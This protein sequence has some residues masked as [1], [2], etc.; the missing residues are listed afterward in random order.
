MFPDGRS[1]GKARGRPQLDYRQ[2][3]RSLPAALLLRPEGQ[4]EQKPASAQQGNSH[5][6]PIKRGRLPT[7]D[8]QGQKLLRSSLQPLQQGG[9]T[10]TAA[11][12]QVEG[13]R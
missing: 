3:A 8:P 4:D 6:S 2:T 7:T 1:S 5:I 12:P 13:S 11:C 10:S 9:T